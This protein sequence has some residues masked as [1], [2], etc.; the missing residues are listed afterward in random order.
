MATP[1]AKD[2]TRIYIAQRADAGKQFGDFAE[3]GPNGK[4]VPK[5]PAAHARELLRYWYAAGVDAIK[6]TGDKPK[7]TRA[8]LDKAWGEFQD[9]MRPFAATVVVDPAAQA[10]TG[11]SL[12]LPF[13]ACVA[14]WD[15]VKGLALAMMAANVA[16]L[17][18]DLWW[19]SLA[20]ATR[21]AARAVGKGAA[22]VVDA[23][24]SAGK[25]ALVVAGLV[26]IVVLGGNKRGR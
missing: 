16:P 13:A 15:A 11:E 1:T 9:R 12:G 5:M 22:A 2:W 24:S 23:A 25:W 8:R 18:G 14:F 3:P 20:E 26:A 7:A 17:A 21:D 10:A 6:R 4:K 19:Q